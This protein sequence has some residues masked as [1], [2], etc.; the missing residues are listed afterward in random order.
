[1]AEL[2]PPDLSALD[3]AALAWFLLAWLGYEGLARAL[4]SPRSIASRMLGMRRAWMLSMLGRDNRITDASLI[5]HAVHS[6]TFFAST[7][8]VALAALLGT[9]GNLDGAHAAV[10]DLA[11]TAKCSRPLLEAKVMLLA[12]VFAHGF[13]K[14]SWAVRQLNHCVALIGAAPLRP[15]A[16]RR[17]AFADRAAAVLSLAVGSF[18]A[19]LRAYYFA[20]AALAWLLGPGAFALATAGIVA[21]LLW[22]QFRSA[23]SEAIR[24]SEAALADGEAGP[25]PRRTGG[26]AEPAGY[27]PGA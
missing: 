15:D 10:Q 26:A 14:L 1:L 22:R 17:D 8:V 20:M 18:D 19:G 21:M 6:A 4:R 3:R 24:R 11:F 7:A 2:M 27:A 23:A 9:L 16:A 13:L 12:L 5:G 25:E